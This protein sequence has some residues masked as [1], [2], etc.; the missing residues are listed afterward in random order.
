MCMRVRVC[1]CACV[2]VCV[3]GA[4]V[5]V[6]WFFGCYFCCCWLLLLLLLL[7]CC[8]CFGF[9]FLFCFLF[10]LGGYLNYACDSV[11][12]SETCT[13]AGETMY[14]YAYFVIS[15]FISCERLDKQTFS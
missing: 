11:S 5:V 6:V 8:C 12:V 3:C 4:V 14:V 10:F 7:F 15:S 13:I 9:V 2:N 1:V